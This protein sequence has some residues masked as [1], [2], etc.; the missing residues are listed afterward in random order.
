MSEDHSQCREELR[1]SATRLGMDVTVSAAPP[2]ALGPYPPHSYI[3]PH[4]T[5]YWIS[6]TGEQIAQWRR[7]GTP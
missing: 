5:T 1:A 2:I 3:C 6:P 7:D 4:G